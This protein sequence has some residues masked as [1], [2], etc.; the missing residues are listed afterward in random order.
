M[1]RIVRASFIFAVS[2]LIPPVRRLWRPKLGAKSI[3]I[4]SFASI[5]S[6]LARPPDVS[7]TAPSLTSGPQ[8][9]VGSSMGGW[10]MLH[11]AL[12]RPERIAALVGLA[13]APDFTEKRWRNMPE[14]QRQELEERGFL[15]VQSCY[16]TQEPYIITKALIEDGR[17]Q[18][19]LPQERL[20]IPAIPV[21]LLHGLQDAD[22]P[23]QTSLTVAEKVTTPDVRVELVKD[24]EHRLS[25]LQ[26]LKLLHRVLKELV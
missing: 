23:W 1:L 9:L 24:G 3:G 18:A 19:L 16:D 5:I 6:A 4:P 12:K 14:N 22:V 26:D 17:R 8:I 20:E 2:V 25:R 7:K 21:R 11:L 10:I 13:A 15:T